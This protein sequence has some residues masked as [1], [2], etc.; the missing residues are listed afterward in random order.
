VNENEE[1]EMGGAIDREMAAETL[2]SV[3]GMRK[4]ALAAARRPSAFEPLVFGL[5]AAIAAPVGLLESDT[6]LSIVLAV[7][8]VAAVAI[9]DLHY[10]REPVHPAAPERRPRS[11]I[12]VILIA[13]LLIVFLPWGIE[14][15]FVLPAAG[16]TVIMFVLFTVGAL[17]LAKRTR[18]DALALAGI[19]SLFSMVA[20]NFIWADHTGFVVASLDCGLFLT[21]ATVARY[22]RRRSA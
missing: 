8:F 13:I 14:F 7:A 22:M 2:R 3:E 12:E 4:K 9:T 19:F 10:Q 11:S 6:W 21:A 5:A 1:G 15:L 20:A 18:N 16:P 17:V